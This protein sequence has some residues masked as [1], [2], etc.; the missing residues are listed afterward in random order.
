MFS[1]F[2]L[3]YIHIYQILLGIC[4]FLLCFSP[5][6]APIGLILVFVGAVVGLIIKEAKWNMPNKIMLGFIVLYLAY[7]IGFIFTDNVPVG[8]KYLEYKLALILIPIVFLIRPKKTINLFSLTVGLILAIIATT[9]I[10]LVQ[11]IQCY[12]ELDYFLE[13]FTSSYLTS[14]HPTYFAVFLTLSIALS[15]YGWK[16]NFPFFKLPLV[17]LYNFVALIMLLLGLS[18]SGISF[19]LLLIGIIVLIQIRRK[20]GKWAALGVFIS[21]PILVVIILNSVPSLKSDIRSSLES[22]QSYISNPNKFLEYDGSHDGDD[23]RLIMWTVTAQEIA[24]H[25]FGVGTGNVDEHLSHKLLKYN[26]KDMAKKDDRGQI[27]YN[28]HNQF[29]QT[30]L[31][32][33]IIGILILMFI[34]Y[35]CV[36]KAIKERKWLLMILTS[37]LAY[38][39]LFESMFQRQSGILFFTFWIIVLSLFEVSKVSELNL[40]SDE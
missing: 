35:S 8:L 36:Y 10:S 40:E 23:V 38:N 31:E 1:K 30:G 26:Q 9:F 20:F 34:L 5:K 11:G 22:F 12:S 7:L 15:W 2:N 19:G 37:C 14:E 17:L 33:G 3:K 16:H 28:P 21:A 29:L 32:V 6:L 13:C 24:R 18:L 4:S 39:C 25:P 27:L